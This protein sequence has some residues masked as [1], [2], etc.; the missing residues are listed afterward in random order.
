[1]GPPLKRFVSNYRN[2]L[3]AWGVIALLL[4][5]GLELG[6]DKTFLGFAV[7]LVGIIGEGFAALLAWIGLIPLVGPLVAKVLALPFFWIL[8]GIGYLASLV[9][10]KRGYSREVINYRILTVVLLIGVT[11]GYVLGK[12]I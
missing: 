6:V 4:I 1:M 3:I 10:I 8:N 9:A 11:I 7:I 5:V 2:A 12:L